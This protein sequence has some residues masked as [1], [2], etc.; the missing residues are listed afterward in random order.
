MAL[1]LCSCSK[2][3]EPKE[4]Y[5]TY[6]SSVVMI[7]NVYYFKAE[8]ENGLKFFY[9]IKDNKPFL[10]KTES[11]AIENANST[12]GT[13]FFIS[14]T[15][16]VAT[17]R[18]VIF[19][20]EQRDIAVDRIMGLVN[21][22]QFKFN[23]DLNELNYQKR[24]VL[25]YKSANNQNLD[26]ELLEELNLLLYDIDQ[27]IFSTQKLIN[28]VGINSRNCKFETINL[29]VG[30]AYDNMH[31]NR[32]TDF[33]EC[34]PIKKS[35]DN[36]IDLAII[37]LKE[38]STPSFVQSYLNLSNIEK[39]NLNDDVFLIGYNHGPVLAQT[40]SGLKNQFMSGKVTR[41]PDDKEIL[42][43]IPTLPGSSGSPIINKNGH[44]VAVNFA[45]VNNGQ[46][47]NFG[48]PAFHLKNLYESP[49][50]LFKISETGRD[51]IQ[52]EL[53]EKHKSKPTNTSIKKPI[54]VDNTESEIPLNGE[55][56]DYEYLTQ[57]AISNGTNIIL[58][59]LPST[60]SKV[61]GS[62]KHPNES[63][64]LLKS[65][66]TENNN[67]RILKNN[68]EITYRGAEYKFLKG[69][70]LFVISR[71]NEHSEVLLKTIEDKEIQVVINNQNISLME[72][73]LWYL[74]KKVD[75]QIGWVYGKFIDIFDN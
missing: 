32:E 42:Y 18:H 43:S 19:P 69:K 50:N 44:L 11:I 56:N 22:M 74:V 60:R 12:F 49:L 53:V 62:I 70:A 5:D 38:K 33:Q 7:K 10:C 31:V 4:I 47:F 2:T 13:G 48:V 26:D 58:R 16:E 57:Y 40:S 61:I 59:K 25:D 9:I 71:N 64:K 52:K 54:E 8:F 35:N 27:K 65:Y 36:N 28:E 30:I 29:F 55:F 41:D 37:Q 23:E 73:E 17:N 24:E 72:E 3:K 34:I 67:E 66:K 51:D 45:G 63:L 6:R 46:G 14:N 21:E 39:L 1:L 20:D 15:G 68:I 75:G